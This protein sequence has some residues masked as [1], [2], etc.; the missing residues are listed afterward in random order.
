M[1]SITDLVNGEFAHLDSAVQQAAIDKALADLTQMPEADQARL[2]AA[3][4]V[5]TQNKKDG[6]VLV[7]TI[8]AAGAVATQIGFKLI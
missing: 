3:L 5:E 4:G 1:G 7:A 6:A 8:R 2:L